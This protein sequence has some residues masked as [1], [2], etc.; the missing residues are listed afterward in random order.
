MSGVVKGSVRTRVMWVVLSTTF[1]SLLLAGTTLLLYELRNY[2]SNRIAEIQS[3]AN[4]IARASAPAISFEDVKAAKENL[5]LLAVRPSINAAAIYKPGGTLFATYSRQPQDQVF[6]VKPPPAAGYS[7][8]GERVY[9]FQRIIENNEVLGTLYIDAAYEPLERLK[10]YLAILGVV[11]LA[12]MSL[13]FAI[14]AWLQ[15]AITEP[16]LASPTSRVK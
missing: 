16:I 2:K 9:H 13:A 7:I 3:L 10:D 8:E 15:G 11:M 4:I 1:A 6:P 5:A 14:S 12:A